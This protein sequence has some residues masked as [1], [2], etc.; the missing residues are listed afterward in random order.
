[1]NDCLTVKGSAQIC[2]VY[3]AGTSLLHGQ[4]RYPELRY[5]LE[6][7]HNEQQSTKKNKQII[8]ISA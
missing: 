8:T 6:R 7:L 3:Y 2:H 4:A 5:H 1:M